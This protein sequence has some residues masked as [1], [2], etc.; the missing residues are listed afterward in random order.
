MKAVPFLDL[1]KINLEID[2]EIRI[3]IDKVINSGWYIMGNELMEF[4]QEMKKHLVAD[5][6]G[7]VVGC[8]SGTDAIILSLLAAGVKPG[9][10]VITVSHTAIPTIAA[11]VGIGATPIFVDINEKTWVMDINKVHNRISAKTKAVIAVHLY[12]NMVDVF[13][14]KDI[15]SDYNR[16]DIAIIEDVA[17]AQG[18]YLKG[19]QAGTIGDFGAFSFY[20]SKNIGALGDGGA[21]L[22]KDEHRYGLL[23]MLRNYGQKDRYNAIMPY[24]LNSRLDEVQASI[25]TVKLKHLSDWNERKDKIM[26]FYRKE[27]QESNFEFQDVTDN[28]RPAWHL[29]VL[30]FPN[31]SK[32][33]NAIQVLKDTGV[34]TLIHY[35]IPT[36]MQKAFLNFSNIDNDLHKTE[37]LAKRILSIPFNTIL[38]DGDKN[39]IVDVLKKL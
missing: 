31:E 7:Y 11:I 6:D 22:C 10:E 37:R 24:G 3:A 29:C 4:E 35:P 32:R 16:E 36:H 13:S 38:T 2:H 1:R 23:C 12:G 34:Q 25:L 14:L 18:A 19:C 26:E 33:D 5:Q 15:L 8:N 28:C 30:A 9:D 17:Q 27:L 39:Y 21:V 20:P